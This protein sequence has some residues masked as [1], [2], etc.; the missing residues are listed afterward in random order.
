MLDWAVAGG[1]SPLE[2]DFYIAALKYLFK[3]ETFLFILL[4]AGTVAAALLLGYFAGRFL[5]RLRAP[6]AHE[7]PPE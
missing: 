6:T 3:V 1:P 4:P 5:N 7:V 2:L